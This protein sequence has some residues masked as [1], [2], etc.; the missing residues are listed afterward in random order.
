MMVGTND[1]TIWRLPL[2]ASMFVIL[3]RRRR[4]LAKISTRSSGEL[5]LVVAGGG[6]EKIK[7]C[8]SPLTLLRRQVNV[9]LI[10]VKDPRPW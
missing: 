3:I 6:D 5:P 7:T 2:S 1:T 8:L 9:Y 4:W 10:T